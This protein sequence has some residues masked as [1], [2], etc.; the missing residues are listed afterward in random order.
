MSIACQLSREFSSVISCEH[1]K[2]GPYTS[3]LGS[4]TKKNVKKPS[5]DIDKTSFTKSFQQL[6]LIKSWL[7]RLGCP[8]LSSLID[9]PIAEKGSIL[10]DI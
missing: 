9:S 10:F 7:E 5:L 1:L 4:A 8:N 3:Y 2:N 6:V